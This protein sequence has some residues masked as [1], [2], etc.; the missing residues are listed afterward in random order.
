RNRIDNRSIY[1]YNMD[2]QCEQHTDKVHTE[3]LYRTETS[4]CKCCRYKTECTDCCKVFHDCK[5]NPHDDFICFF[6]YFNESWY[7]IFHCNHRDT[8]KDCESNNL[9]HIRST[10]RFNDVC[11]DDINQRL[12]KR[13][14]DCFTRFSTEFV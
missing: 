4:L 10:H 8:D 14:V 12:V 13:L 6:K 3:L 11:R 5:H 1:V 7:F 9:K 2:Q